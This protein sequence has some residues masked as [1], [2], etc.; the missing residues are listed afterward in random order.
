[1]RFS[2]KLRRQ[3]GKFSRWFWWRVIRHRDDE[4]SSSPVWLV[5]SDFENGVYYADGGA[6]ST[7]GGVWIANPGDWG[8]FNSETDISAEGLLS[9]GAPLLTITAKAELLG[10]FT[11]LLDATVAPSSNVKLSWVEF[12]NYGER[13][14]ALWAH[15]AIAS[16][17][18]NDEVGGSE[19]VQGPLLSEG[20]HLVAFTLTETHL[21]ICINNGS[22]F[23]IEVTEPDL[24]LDQIGPSPSGSSVLHRIAFIAPVDDAELSSL[25]FT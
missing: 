3:F 21:A 7:V 16:E 9:T 2:A 1:M 18:R 20:R 12:D 5:D 22:V 13:F 15:E 14:G 19:S 24:P 10:G 6:I 25:E 11:A 17:V 4:E 8:T 23:S